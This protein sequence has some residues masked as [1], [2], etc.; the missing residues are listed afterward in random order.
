MEDTFT[1]HLNSR[2]VRALKEAVEFTLA[3]W[4]GQEPI[5]QEALMAMRPEFHKMLL[6]IM[7]LWDKDS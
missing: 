6:E 3:K 4:G 1:L 7:Y 2:S 5:D